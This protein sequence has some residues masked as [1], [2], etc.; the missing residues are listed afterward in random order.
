MATTKTKKR[1]GKLVATFPEPAD[2]SRT[3]AARSFPAIHCEGG[4]R[5]AAGVRLQRPQ[6]MRSA[7]PGGVAVTGPLQVNNG[8]PANDARAKPDTRKPDY[9]RRAMVN[10]WTPERRARQAEAI[11]RWQPWAR[12]TGPRTAEGKARAK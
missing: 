7:E 8:V 10:G 4:G 1:K 5:H 2:T 3:V 9:W 11:R 12:S 6:A